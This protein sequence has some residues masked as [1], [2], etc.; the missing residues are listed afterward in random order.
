MKRIDSLKPG[1]KVVLQFGREFQFGDAEQE[2]ATFLGIEGTGDDRRAKF[3]QDFDWEAYR[4]NGRWAY[5]TS[6]ESLRLVRII[7]D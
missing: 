7:Q 3:R 6:A 5:G 2:E 4:Y 1:T